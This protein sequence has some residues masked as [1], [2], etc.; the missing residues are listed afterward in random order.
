MALHEELEQKRSIERLS[1]IREVI[2]LISN[3]LAIP[4]YL[5]FWICDIL[6]VPNLKWPFLALRLSIVPLCIFV[7]TL[8]KKTDNYKT[9]QN[10]SIIFIG[11]L[12]STIN[13]MIM[14]I[15][16][17]GTP[18][19]AGLNLV[20]LGTLSFIPW[21]K[22][23]YF[24][25]AAAIYMPYFAWSTI[26]IFLGEKPTSF[27]VSTFFIVG[28]VTISFIMRYF[29]ESLRKKELKSRIALQM[30]VTSRDSI[31]EIKT[32]EAVK[33]TSLSKQFSPQ[34]VHAISS[35]KI[36][37]ENSLM[38]SNICS[39]F[40]D[41]VSSTDRITRLDKD[42]INKVL[43]FFMEDTMKVLLKYDI[44]IDKFLGDG[45]LA[46]S[47]APIQHADYIKR[48]VDAAL[49]IRNRIAA[50]RDRYLEIWLNELQIRVGI[51]S[52]YANVGF[53]GSQ[54]YFRSYT[55]IGKVVNLAS[56]LC[57]VAEPSQ[58]LVSQDVAK[59]LDS[60]QY[61]LK[62]V[63]LRKLK[64][65]EQD[66]INVFTVTSSERD[67][68]SNHNIP[69]CPQ[70]HGILHLETNSNGIYVLKCRTCGIVAEPLTNNDP[71]RRVA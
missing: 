28:T 53:Y 12:A 67:E 31:I 69:S 23:Y 41:I 48:V 47:N 71:L 8:I 54:E 4:L 60:N 30:E 49:E 38:R 33:L 9:A 59:A 64:G 39:I 40:I 5:I 45:V 22:V 62:N 68:L 6:Y 51:S 1:E 57:S 24:S 46:F 43:S 58:I 50:N 26:K 15:N 3:N 32:N 7:R 27:F 65:F 29:N 18:Y 16:D 2:D 19:Y 21:S 34:V 13:I 10:I 14:I 63:G 61:E 44:T 42:D 17:P 70:G 11:F 36:D 56:R 35:G 52:G 37:I 55:A 66:I 25:T 20:A